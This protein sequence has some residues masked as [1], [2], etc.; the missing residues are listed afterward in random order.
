MASS[1]F[2]LIFTLKMALWCFCN[3]NRK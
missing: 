2:I 3:S 1:D